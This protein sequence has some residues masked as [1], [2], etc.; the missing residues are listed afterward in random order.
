M[1]GTDPHS[2][3]SFSDGESGRARLF[4]M[5]QRDHRAGPP[6]TTAGCRFPPFVESGP[7]IGCIGFGGPPTHIALLRRL[8]VEERQWIEPR[9]FEDGI[10]ATNLLPGPASTQMAIFCALAAAGRVGWRRGGLCFIVPG[11]ALILALSAAFLAATPRLGSSARR[12]ERARRFP[13]SPLKAASDSFPASWR[14]VGARAREEARWVLYALVG[15]RPARP[16][17]VPYLVLDAAGLRARRDR[18]PRARP[19]RAR[20]LRLGSSRRSAVH[21]GTIGGLGALAWVAFKVG[22]LSYGG[23]FVIVPLMQH[24]AV[25]PTTG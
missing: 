2:H 19:D 4:D 24:D 14:R 20:T 6:S 16:R 15:R 10:A 25:S 11:L 13:P 1:A 3:R 23:G 5:R 8:C 7:W 22:A 9:E 21:T 18:R 17:L 12:P